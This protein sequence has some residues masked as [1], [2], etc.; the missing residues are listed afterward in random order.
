MLTYLQPYTVLCKCMVVSHRAV[1]MCTHGNCW[2]HSTLLLN[3]ELGEKVGLHVELGSF[4]TLPSHAKL[5]LWPWN[6]V[7]MEQKEGQLLRL[8]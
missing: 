8:C 5:L 3:R 6:R 2:K 1:H 7:L 4:V